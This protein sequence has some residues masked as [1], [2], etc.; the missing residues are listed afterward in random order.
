LRLI[1]LLYLP[2]SVGTVTLVV[3]YNPRVLLEMLLCCF[4]LF[5]YFCRHGEFSGSLHVQPSGVRGDVVVLYLPISVFLFIGTVKLV[6]CYNP[7]LLGEM[8]LCCIYLFLY[9]CL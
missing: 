6:V 3:R 2:I 8:S 5:L 4:Y 1:G 9:F 7:R